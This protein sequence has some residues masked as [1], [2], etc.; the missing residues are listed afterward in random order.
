MLQFKVNLPARKFY[1]TTARNFLILLL[2]IASS[3]AV[4]AQ[5]AKVTDNTLPK[6]KLVVGIVIDQMRWDYLYRFYDRYGETGFKR[7]LK[8]GFSCENTLINY[9]PSVTAVGHSTIYTG[10]VPA[11]HGITDNNW[12]DRASGKSVYCTSDSAVQSVGTTGKSGQMSPRNLLASTITDELAIASNFQSKIVGVSLKDRASILPAG[13]TP[14]AAFWLDDDSGNFI[15]SSYYMQQLPKW[16]NDFNQAKHIDKLIAKDWHTLY[17]IETYTQSLPDN[18]IWEGKF[19]GETE[20]IFPHLISSV[21]KNSREDFRDTP[22]GNTL[23]LE[24]AKATL[25]AYQLG[26]GSAT[27]FLAINCASTDY[28]GHMYGPNSVEVEDVYLRLD[29]DLGA[30]FDALDKKVG[31]GNYTVFLTADHGASN[32]IKFNQAHKIPSE[33]V[34]TGAI[35]ASLNE[36]LKGKFDVEKLVTRVSSYQVYYNA[37]LIDKKKLDYNLVKQESINF[38]RKQPGISFAVDLD[39]IQAAS[40]PN[41]IKERIINGYNYKRS[42]DV[43]IISD[44]GWFSGGSTGTTHGLYGP[45]DTHIPLIFMGWGI[46]HGATNRETYMTDIAPT[47]AAFL[48][49]QMPNGAIGKPIV[50]VLSK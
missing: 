23:T 35:R 4:Q 44:P 31:K 1:F 19:K 8:Q 39:N 30:F 6:P 33:N 29:K 48:H 21:Y 12:I 43:Q 50:E 3:F 37:D 14:T 7:L 5:K 2:L 36:Y 34:N 28:V 11:I 45:T 22:F 32:S 24:F 10:S 15:T 20:S 17:P 41:Y 9:I 40:I 26:K 47:V 38:L 46:K 18:A 49:I 42:G 27:D 25:D 13:H 16:V